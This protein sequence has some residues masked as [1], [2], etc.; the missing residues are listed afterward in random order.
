MIPFR[1]LDHLVRLVHRGTPCRSQEPQCAM[2][3]GSVASIRHF[4]VAG[5]QITRLLPIAADR[6][7]MLL[8]DSTFRSPRTAHPH[9]VVDQR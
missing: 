6:S 7:T 5:D 4:G 2:T 9:T 1:S 8:L 3:K